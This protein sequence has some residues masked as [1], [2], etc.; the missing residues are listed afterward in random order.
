MFTVELKCSLD[1][2]RRFLCIQNL[3]PK[4]KE[5]FNYTLG[6][7]FVFEPIKEEEGATFRDTAKREK[8][9]I[10]DVGG[11]LVLLAAGVPD[12]KI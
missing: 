10:E 12:G 6:T 4:T 11:L 9:K 3:K 7:G 2:T 1:I 5:L 8:N